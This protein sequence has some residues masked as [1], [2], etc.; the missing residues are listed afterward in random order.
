M[1][2]AIRCKCYILAIS[3]CIIIF[4]WLNLALAKD[5]NAYIDDG[6]KSHKT[7][8]YRDSLKAFDAALKL[9][10]GED[11]S[12]MA[13]NGLSIACDLLGEYEKALDYS[14]RALLIHR[15]LHNLPGEAADLSTIGI[16]YR[17][18]GKYEKALD[19]F[20]R[21]LSISRTTQDDIGEGNELHN[22]G[23]VLEDLGQYEKALEHYHDALKKHRIMNDHINETKDLHSIAIVLRKFGEYEKSLEYFNQVYINSKAMN[24]LNGVAGAIYSIGNLY[25]HMDK[26]DKALQFFHQSLEIYNKIDNTIGE[27]INCEGIGIAYSGTMQ[28][29]K[30][31]TYY[32]RALQTYKKSGDITSQSGILNNIGLNCLSLGQ[33]DKAEV[34]LSEAVRI[35]ESIRGNVSGESERLGFQSTYPYVYGSLATARMALG[36]PES[37]FEA[38]ERGRAKSFLDLLE[39]SEKAAKHSKERVLESPRTQHDRTVSSKQH[40]P[41]VE[42]FSTGSDSVGSKL[43]QSIFG[44]DRKRLDRVEKKTTADPTR[45]WLAVAAPPTLKEIHNM[46]GDALLIEYYHK[47]PYIISNKMIDELW[48]FLIYRSGFEFRKVKVG[49]KDLQSALDR[50]ASLSA[51]RLSD[52]N[53][54]EAVSSTLYRWLIEPIEPSILK[55]NPRTLVVV[56]WDS[57]FKIPFGS[58]ALKGGKP[59]ATRASIVIAPSA[60]VCRYVIKKRASGHRS[61]L[62]MGNPKT[63]LQPLPG[64]E[65]EVK[66]IVSLFGKPTPKTREQATET[67]LKAVPFESGYPDVIHLACHGILNE[68]VPQL[69]YLALAAD[70]QNDGKLEVCELFDLD[71]RGVSLVTLSACFSG[72]GKLGAGDDL[73]GMVRGLMFAGAPSILASLWKVNDDVTCALMAEFYQNYISGMSKPDSLRNAQLAIMK[74]W[75]HPYYWAGFVLFGAWE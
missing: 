48:I 60:G 65:P 55:R 2:C 58:L 59:L 4:G 9:A 53:E 73:L 74:K 68:R 5:F 56:P 31:Q 51:N 13:M 23:S 39:T 28:Y 22:I 32:N 45:G 10:P 15:K 52:R 42:S 47:G 71:L 36:N 35:F 50:Y 61:V 33:I 24:D 69:S 40:L 27:A 1:Q 17:H 8:R 63:D 20:Q 38:I 49:I 11:E 75:T 7:G 30:A 14:Q 70:Q 12:A 66:Q 41:D 62:A 18:L 16:V 72:R 43:D 44:R 3:I 67:L 21:S 64:A 54:F 34:E 46:L 37:A 19:Y 26:Y 57:M 25:S 29:K 6:L